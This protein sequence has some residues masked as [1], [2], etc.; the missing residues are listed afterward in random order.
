MRITK[1]GEYGI[2]C[3]SYLASKFEAGSAASA[4][5]ISEAQ[6]IPLQYTQ[7][8]LHR[9]RKGGV[10]KS[11]RGPHGGFRLTKSPAET[12]L[13]DI[14]YAA[15]GKTFELICDTHPLAPGVCDAETDCGLKAVWQDLRETIDLV[16]EKKTLASI[17]ALSGLSRQQLVAAPVRHVR[18]AGNAAP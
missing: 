5:E 16:L 12:T 10:I 11:L 4:A 13:K 18:S 2:L 17:S 7:Q 6:N 15:E 8:I 3:S 9:L 1:W 14:L